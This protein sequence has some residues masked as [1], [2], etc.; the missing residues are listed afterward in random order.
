MRLAQAI[1]LIPQSFHLRCGC[2]K[3][4]E[5]GEL[6]GCASLFEEPPEDG[7]PNPRHPADKF[8]AR[9]ITSITTEETDTEA[10]ELLT[11]NMIVGQY[12]TDRQKAEARD[13]LD[14]M[15]A[16]RARGRAPSCRRR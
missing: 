2:E 10:F 16:R 3:N 9:T 5:T 4:P 1:L 13:Q 14:Q 7:W 12:G 8:L 11:V 6:F 15:S